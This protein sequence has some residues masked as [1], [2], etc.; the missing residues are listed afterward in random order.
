MPRVP[1]P[2]R[3][4]ALR[5]IAVAE[6]DRGIRGLLEAI[7][8]SDNCSVIAAQDGAEALRLADLHHVDLML[9][10]LNMP[11]ASFV[12]PT[13]SE[14]RLFRFKLRVYDKLGADSLPAFVDVTVEP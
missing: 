8:R 13:V 12:A 10:D 1:D 2:P 3:D 7:L 6:D 9:V 5:V 4:L 11:R 14:P